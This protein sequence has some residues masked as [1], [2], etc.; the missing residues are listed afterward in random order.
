MRKIGEMPLS[1]R[2]LITLEKIYILLIATSSQL[3]LLVRN[4]DGITVIVIIFCAYRQMFH[5]HLWDIFENIF[6]K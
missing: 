6:N 4:I 1:S 5:L 3:Y 2:Y